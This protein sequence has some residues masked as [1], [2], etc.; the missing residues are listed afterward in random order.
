LRDFSHGRGGAGPSVLVVPSLINRSTILDL[1]PDRS[2][3]RTMAAANVR[4]F[5]LDWGVP[6]IDERFYTVTDYVA[7]VLLPAVDKV[8]AE[9]GAPPRLMG[10][11]MGGT[12]AVAAAVLASTRISGLAVVAAPWDFHVDT[13]AVRALLAGARP[14]IETIIMVYGEAPFDLLQALFALLDP[15]LVGRKFRRFATVDQASD[16]AAR[17]VVLEDWLND[18]VPLAAS[19][20]RE[21][22]FA[23]YGDN[24]P[25][26]GQ[27]RVDGR[28]IDPAQITC[29][30]LAVIPARDRI[31]PPA[32][33]MALA[34]AM[35]NAMVRQNP[36]G[37]IGMMASSRAASVTY[38]PLIAW[39]RTPT[40]A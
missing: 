32:S 30:V 33:A 29:P 8:I 13:M 40:A 2:M 5:L 25:A 36:L 38:D 27:W 37:H 16:D 28:V 21:C 34:R 24:T 11:C 23:W 4:T 31:V 6:G 18:P 17:F 7:G 1:S 22:L 19:V 15:T 20:A 12:L 35:P 14:F 26:R 39:L 3:L 9:T 10:Y